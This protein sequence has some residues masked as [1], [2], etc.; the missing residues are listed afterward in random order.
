MVP[1]GGVANLQ[2]VDI[3]E[4]KMGKNLAKRWNRC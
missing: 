1:P 3:L 2:V 4:A